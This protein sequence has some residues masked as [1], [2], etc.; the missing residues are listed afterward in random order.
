MNFL[1]I[2]L[3]LILLSLRNLA[4]LI[5]NLIVNSLQND[6][7]TEVQKILGR[8]NN[9]KKAYH[10]N[11]DQQSV[12]NKSE[13]NSRG[14]ST[15]S[16]LSSSSQKFANIISVIWEQFI[17]IF[18]RIKSANDYSLD[19]MCAIVSVNIFSKTWDGSNWKRY[20]KGILSWKNLNSKNL[21]KID[22]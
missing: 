22:A 8:L 10:N 15:N 12:S 3:K 1:H 14:F 20:N 5:P 16:S 21:E 13:T 7:T 9:I 11:F 4:K 6:Y 17:D 2:F 18:D 19:Q